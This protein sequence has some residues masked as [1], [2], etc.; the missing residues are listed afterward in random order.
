MIV[1]S[2]DCKEHEEY[3]GLGW[4]MVG[5]PY[6][7]PLGGMAVAHDI[8]EH[9]PSDNGSVEEEFMALG[10][11]LLV[12]DGETYFQQKGN[13]HSAAANIASDFVQHYHAIIQNGWSLSFREPGRY[14]MPSEVRDD[15]KAIIAEGRRTL[16]DEIGEDYKEFFSKSNQQKA[17][18]WFARGYRKARRRYR[19]IPAY[20]LCHA[21][22][23]IERQ[24]D[25]HLKFA[26]EGQRLKVS[27]DLARNRVET[28]VDYPEYE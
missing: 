7:E 15:I 17:M 20:S 24:A 6:M 10:A 5:K 11:S 1:R 2:F 18:G 23:E 21:F 12:R 9:F 8:L 25:K 14:R 27:V 13:M 22:V 19:G 3:G 26:E 4:A 28:S 16:R